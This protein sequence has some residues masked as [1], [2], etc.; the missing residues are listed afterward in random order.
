MCISRAVGDVDSLEKP[1]KIITLRFRKVVND[2]AITICNVICTCKYV[3][4]YKYIH[5]PS[6][7]VLHK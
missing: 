7:L 4:K 3:R 5:L 6:Q 2:H 1:H